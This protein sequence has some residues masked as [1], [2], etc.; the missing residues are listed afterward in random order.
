MATDLLATVR[1]IDTLGR[2][3]RVIHDN[4][5]SS[6]SRDTR[7]EIEEFASH[8]ERRLTKISRQLSLDAFKFQPAQGIE[9]KKKSGGIRPLVIAPVESRIV[10]RSIH[11]VLLTVPAIR[12][13][14]ENPFSFGGVRK[15]KGQTRGAVP[16]AIQAVVGTLGTRRCYVTRS[17]I[18]SFFTRISKAE[19][20]RIVEEATAQP[21]FVDLFRA[22]IAVELA[23]MASLRDFAAFPIHEIGVAQGNCLS[24]LLGNLLLASFDREMNAQGAHCFR[25]IDDF[26]IL[27]ED[28]T[29]A[30][31]QFSKAK[32]LLRQHGMDVNEKTKR[33]DSISGFE[34]LGIEIANGAVR[35]SRASRSR[36]LTNISAI[37]EDGKLAL[38]QYRRSGHIDPHDTLVRIL[39]EVR[40]TVMGWGRHYSFCNETNVLQQMDDSINQMLRS[41][42]G[43][44]GNIAKRASGLNAK[45]RILGVPLLQDL[46]RDPLVW[47]APSSRPVR[48]APLHAPLSPHQSPTASVRRPRCLDRS[49]TVR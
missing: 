24:P 12:Q 20:T 47:G 9:A 19:V 43:L 26:L 40:L 10:Q 44:Y 35:P 5:R 27:A 38:R 41:Y 28:P 49:S 39:Q 16:A 17:D 15:A 11:D 37:L 25:Y 23:N 4:G 30:E 31:E 8:A 22:A 6:Q 1:K 2:A 29:A 32:R 13:L 42:L 48:P 45:R 46:T 36:L 18:A 33:S 3:W 14:A 34:F 21:K 7:R